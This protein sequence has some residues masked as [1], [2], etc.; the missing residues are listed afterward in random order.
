M[1]VTYNSNVTDRVVPDLAKNR[2][3]ESWTIS[4]IF[5][6]FPDFSKVQFTEPLLWPMS[7]CTLCATLKENSSKKSEKLAKNEEKTLVQLALNPIFPGPNSKPEIQVSGIR[8]V[9]IL[10]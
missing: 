5:G 9:T 1:Y 3:K 8:S 2:F 4:S 6:K 10:Y 7:A